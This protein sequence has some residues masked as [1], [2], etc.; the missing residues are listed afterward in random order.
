MYDI[1][2]TAKKE[3]FNLLPYFFPRYTNTQKDLHISCIPSY[4]NIASAAFSRTPAVYR[5]RS[6]HEY[7]KNLTKEYFLQ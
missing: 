6:A 2:K 1:I 5:D 7:Y 3:G 4:A